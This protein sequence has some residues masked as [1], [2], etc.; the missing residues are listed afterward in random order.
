M[1]EATPFKINRAP[2]LTLWAAIVAERLG[3]DHDEALTLG[4]A[5]AGLNAQAKGKRLG[6][7]KPSADSLREKRK[8][9]PAGVF[10]VELLHRAVPAVMTADG[11]RA[12]SKGKPSNPEAVEK[13]LAAKFGPHLAATV[14]AMAELAQSFTPGELADLG[15]RLYECFRPAIPEG[16]EGWGAAGALSLAAIHGAGREV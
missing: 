3:F 8:E 12:T 15:F 2:V 14:A 16:V 10:E 4:R 13:Y 1:A 9:K 7:F 5:V 6:I 11:I